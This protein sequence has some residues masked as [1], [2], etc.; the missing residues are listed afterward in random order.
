MSAFCYS[1]AV[2][3]IIKN[4]HNKNPGCL[5]SLAFLSFFFFSEWPNSLEKIL[6]R[7]PCQLHFFHTICC[8]SV[9]FCLRC[10]TESPES[11]K[12]V[13]ESWAGPSWSISYMTKKGGPACWMGFCYVRQ[14]SI[15]YFL[16]VKSLT[17]NYSQSHINLCN[18]CSQNANPWDWGC[19]N[20][21]W[22]LWSKVFTLPTLH[23]TVSLS[24][25]ISSDLILRG[26]SSHTR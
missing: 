21:R 1:V 9:I 7:H 19:H 4:H 6:Y 8:C 24:P 25:V 26:S 5:L 2:Q 13:A 12:S 23:Q 11:F 18:L 17:W 15:K 16:K 10:V 22:L 3:S 14:L 20:S